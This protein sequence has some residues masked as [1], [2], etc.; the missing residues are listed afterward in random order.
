MYPR[1]RLHLLLCGLLVAPPAFAGDGLYGAPSNGTGRVAA[2]D[3]ADNTAITANPGLLGLDSVF[4]AA[5]H[6][7]LG[8][9]THTEWA[10]SLRDSWTSKLALGVAVRREVANPPLRFGDLPG[11]VQ[12]GVTPDHK[13]RSYVITTGLALPTGNRRWSF[14]LNGTVELANDDRTGRRTTGN[15]DVGFGARPVDGVTFGLAVKN[16]VPV[17]DQEDYPLGILGGV[18]LEAPEAGAFELDVDAR[19]E[20]PGRFPVSFRTGAEW[21]IQSARPRLGYRYEGFAGHHW[22]TAGI[23]GENE[24]GG[25]GY[26]LA[27][28]VCKGLEFFDLQHQVGIFVHLDRVRPEETP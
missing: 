14:G 11:W 5:A 18:R 20:D 1:K 6:G 16:V 22:I 21:A 17:P 19:F 26:A 13:T 25:I 10:A 9:D 12:P 7:Q 15:G 4:D 3:A 28:P 23:G 2:A 8:S 24:W 27:V